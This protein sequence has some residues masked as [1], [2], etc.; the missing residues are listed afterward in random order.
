MIQTFGKKRIKTE[1]MMNA[2]EPPPTTFLFFHL[3]TLTLHALVE[4]AVIY[5]MCSIEYNGIY[6]EYDSIVIYKHARVCA[7]VVPVHTVCYRHM[8]STH[9]SK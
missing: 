4:M 7:Y 1:N 9:M 5:G 6:Y 3:A 8:Y 2:L